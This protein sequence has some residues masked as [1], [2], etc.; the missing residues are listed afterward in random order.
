[1]KEIAL[2]EDFDKNN[3]LLSKR[4]FEI[5]ADVALG[6]RCAD[7]AKKRFISVKTVE[8]HRSNILKKTK[9]KNMIQLCS[10]LTKQ[11]LLK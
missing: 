6:L 4:E 11:G 2:K 9:A 1:M 7:I 5:L 8:V 10:T 3:V